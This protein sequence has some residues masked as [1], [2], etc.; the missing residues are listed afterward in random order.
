MILDP[1][2]VRRTAMPTDVD[3][4]AMCGADSLDDIHS[5]LAESD[6]EWADLWAD[7]GP[8]NLTERALKTLI[9]GEANTM[10]DAA[11]ENGTK[12]TESELEQRANATK[13]VADEIKRHRERRKRY[14]QLAE[15]RESLLRQYYRGESKLKAFANLPRG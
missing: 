9:S 5:T 6:D 13:T 11:K 15:F 12:I 14:Q 7:Y 4:E 3:V 1:P 10:R 2:N 8:G